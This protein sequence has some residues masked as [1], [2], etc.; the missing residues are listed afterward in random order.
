RYTIVLNDSDTIENLYSSLGLSDN[1][2]SPLGFS[3]FSSCED[4]PHLGKKIS[5]SD[6][7]KKVQDHAKTRLSQ[8]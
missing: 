7:P 3:Q 8:C 4:G 6:L 1:P 2:D 5:F